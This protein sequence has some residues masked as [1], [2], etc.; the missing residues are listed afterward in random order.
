MNNKNQQKSVL[1]KI[2]R[3]KAISQSIVHL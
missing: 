2:T 3:E 1:P